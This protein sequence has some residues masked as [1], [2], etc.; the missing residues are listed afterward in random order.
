M[1]AS[2]FAALAGSSV[3]AADGALEAGELDVDALS[4]GMAAA[5]RDGIGAVLAATATVAAGSSTVGLTGSD[6]VVGTGA[7]VVLAPVG[8]L[9]TALADASW[10]A[11]CAAA[12]IAAAGVKRGCA[13]DARRPLLEGQKITAPPIT[14]APTIRCAVLMR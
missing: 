2:C 13:L 6:G 4:A 1:L 10:S 11:A 9:G 3:E 5:M 12:A 7:T 8:A 14:T